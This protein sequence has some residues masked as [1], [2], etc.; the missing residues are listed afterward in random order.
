[1]KKCSVEGCENKSVARGICRKHYG[2]L[3]KTGSLEV[4][5]DVSLYKGPGTCDKCEFPGCKHK[6]KAGGL[7][8]TH[9]KQKLKYGKPGSTLGSNKNKICSVDGCSEPSYSKGMC[10]AH[11]MRVRNHGDPSVL[12][13]HKNVGDCSVCGERKAKSLGMCDRCYYNW[14]ASWDEN[15]RL[16][17]GLRN[18]RRRAARINAPSERYTR[19]QVLEKTSGKCGICGK[20]IDLSIK[21]PNPLCFTYDHIFPVSKGGDNT[22]EN[23][24]PAHFSCNSSKRDKVE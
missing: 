7:C 9:Y 14:K 24:Q 20:E 13:R 16:R 21:Y 19:E 4:K 6:V 3:T 8:H 1:M 2:R 15:Y 11:Y 22:L 12:L 17:M 18:N 10:V 23:I 5:R